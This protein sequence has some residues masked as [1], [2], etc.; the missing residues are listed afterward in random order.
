M[1][2]GGLGHLFGCGEVDETVRLIHRRA[3]RCPFFEQFGPFS[4]SQDLENSH[5]IEV[6]PACRNVKAARAARSVAQPSQTRF[7]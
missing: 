7:T 5:G 3:V 2:R 1:A 6:P 4:G